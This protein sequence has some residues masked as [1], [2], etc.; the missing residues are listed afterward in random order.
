MF[1]SMISF[2]K[3]IIVTLSKWI[4]IGQTSRGK[5]EMADKIL[6]FGEEVYQSCFL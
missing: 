6:A 4:V 3:M 1:I 5:T 2:D